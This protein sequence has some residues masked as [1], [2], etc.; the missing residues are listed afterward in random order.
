[1]LALYHAVAMVLG[2]LLRLQGG[3][4][5]LPKHAQLQD[6]YAIYTFYTTHACICTYVS[7]DGW[8]TRETRRL[9][10]F[11]IEAGCDVNNTVETHSLVHGL[12]CQQ[13]Q[14]CQQGQQAGQ[15]S[16][17]VS[18]ERGPTQPDVKTFARRE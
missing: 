9:F 5:Q 1:M 6:P 17:A 11:R 4:L 13:R 14:A 3:H 16:V 7:S 2:N 18:G 10:T 12:T 8:G 15:S